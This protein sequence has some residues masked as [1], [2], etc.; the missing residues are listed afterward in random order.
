MISNK[1]IACIIGTRPEAIKLAPVISEL[2]RS[3][4]F[5]SVVITTGQHRELL[6]KMLDRLEIV[7][8][9]H[10]DLMTE[11]QGLSDLVSRIL[12]RLEEVFS[13]ENVDVVLGQGDTA[14]TFCAALTAFHK[15]I[16]FGHIEAGLRTNDL[17]NPFPE[18]GYRQMISKIS[19]WNFAP[20]QSAADNLVLEGIS[21]KRI[22]VTGNT[23]I[24]SLLLHAGKPN[25]QAVDGKRTIL[26]TAHR[27]ENFGEPIKSIFRAVNRIV[28]RFDDVE[29]VYPVHPNPNVSKLAMIMLG[30][31]PRIILKSPLDY[32][33]FI[34]AMKQS[35]L[36]LTDSGGIQ[37]EAPALGKP[38]LVMRETT[39][40]PEAVQNGHALLVGVDETAIFQ[41][42][43]KLL[44]DS[45]LLS[46]MSRPGFPFGDGMAAGRIVEI[47]KNE[48]ASCS[49]ES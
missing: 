12:P 6:N 8:D 37:E 34:D 10:L 40:R 28:E 46:A 29:V 32:F 22:H 7:P 49:A 41:A 47:L 36:I 23:G 31:H 27:R 33:E 42:A 5:R 39:E 3:H 11:G 20:T 18:E 17:G 35:T 14:T 44:V 1:V 4:N 13:K 16:P 25:G 19:R 2:K 9:H 21:L 43:E 26:L 45:G 38:V 30:K 48:W 24:D 15:K